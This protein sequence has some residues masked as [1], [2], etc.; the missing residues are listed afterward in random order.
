MIIIHFKVTLIVFLIVFCA[1]NN[2]LHSYDD[3]KMLNQTVNVECMMYNIN[4]NINVD[5]SLKSYLENIYDYFVYY[6]FFYNNNDY[7]SIV[8][9]MNY[10]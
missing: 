5:N 9:I 10:S 8:D 4:P 7:K 1:I 6:I 2:F 3:F